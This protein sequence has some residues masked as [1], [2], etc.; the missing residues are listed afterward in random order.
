MPSASIGLRNSSRSNSTAFPLSQFARPLTFSSTKPTGS[1][2]L[3]ILTNSNSS[4]P[5]SSSSP[6]RRPAMLKL[7]QGGPPMTRAASPFPIFA[8]LRISSPVTSL[9]L[10]F[11]T[12]RSGLLNRSVSQ[13]EVSISTATAVWNPAASNPMSKPPAPENKLIIFGLSLYIKTLFKTALSDSFRLKRIGVASATSIVVKVVF[14]FN[15]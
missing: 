11:I 5:R 13:Q 3:T 1:V 15:L 6:F 10:L 8:A 9:M 14:F 12:H 4:F 7:W 2:S